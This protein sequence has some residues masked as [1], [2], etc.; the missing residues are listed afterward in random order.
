[1]NIIDKIQQEQM[2]KDVTKFNVGD[3]VR[4]HTKVKEGEKERI[5][6]FSGIVIGRKGA[7]RRSKSR[8]RVR[9]AARSSITSAIARASKPW[10][11]ARRDRHRRNGD[12][13]SPVRR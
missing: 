3:S 11:C 5:Q 6:I 10:R 9:H 8:H 2:K 4:V 7:S 13:V 1:M 12:R